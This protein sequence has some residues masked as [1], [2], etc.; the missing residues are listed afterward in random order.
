MSRIPAWRL[1]FQLRAGTTGNRPPSF[2]PES[3]GYHLQRGGDKDLYQLFCERYSRLVRPDGHLGVVL[4]RTC[5]SCQ[6]GLKGF[7][8]WLYSPTT[9]CEGLIFL[10]NNK[11]LGFHLFMLNG[12]LR[13]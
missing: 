13:C 8:Q 5:V 6:K 3:G 10:L 1:E 11:R 4:S 7:R 9:V 2:S 12:R